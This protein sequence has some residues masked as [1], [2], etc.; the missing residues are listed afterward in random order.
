VPVFLLFCLL[1]LAVLLAMA[2]GLLS[3]AL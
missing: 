2:A 1:V 3:E